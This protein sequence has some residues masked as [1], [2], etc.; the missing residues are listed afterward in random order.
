MRDKSSSSDSSSSSADK[1]PAKPPAGAD[2]KKTVDKKSLDGGGK[3]RAGISSSAAPLTK[4]ALTKGGPTPTGGG[5]AQHQQAA[6]PY[7][8]AQQQAPYPMVKGVDLGKGAHRGGV[9]GGVVPPG[10][11][12]VPAAALALGAGGKMVMPIPGKGGKMV[13]A[14]PAPG[15]KPV[16]MVIAAPGAPGGKPVR[17]LFFSECFSMFLLDVHHH[18]FETW[19]TR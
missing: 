17:F 5:V 15:G 12:V 10:M 14:A 3:K 8:G 4:G 6:G 16:G 2:N 7:P 1:K 18:L 9:G 19:W 13:I 11:A